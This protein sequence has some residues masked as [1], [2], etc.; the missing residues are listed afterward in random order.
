MGPKKTK[1]ILV[2]SG[3]GHLAEM[4]QL[5]EMF[6]RYD[7]LMVT[8]N[9]EYTSFFKEQ[10]NMRFIKARSAGKKRRFRFLMTLIANTFLSLKLLINHYPKVIISTGSHT[11]IPMCL[12]GRL[13]GIKIVFILSYAR[14]H[15]RAKAADIIYPIADRFILQWPEGK[16]NYEKAVFV[17]GL[18]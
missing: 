16:N 5:E 12:L 6:T 11:A 18:Y 15:S 7:Y 4:L 10:Y 17:G 1:I 2:C 13:F 14:V 9:T 3:G 8:E